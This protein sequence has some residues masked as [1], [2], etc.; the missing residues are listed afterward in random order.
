MKKGPKTI[1]HVE[2]KWTHLKID[3]EGQLPV[4]VGLHKS[5]F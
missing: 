3:S 2:Q 4:F 5:G 1:T